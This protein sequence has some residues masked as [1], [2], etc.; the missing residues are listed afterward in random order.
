MVEFLDWLEM[1]PR[2]RSSRALIVFRGM[3]NRH[4]ER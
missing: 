4:Q 1:S 3:D 2:A